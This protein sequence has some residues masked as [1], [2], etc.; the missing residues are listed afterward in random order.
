MR[1]RG[2]KKAENYLISTFKLRITR[3]H[4][5]IYLE[6]LRREIQSVKIRIKKSG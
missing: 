4:L 3:N 6:S 5:E 1:L 2:N